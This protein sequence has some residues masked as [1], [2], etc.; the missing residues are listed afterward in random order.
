[1]QFAGAGSGVR[2]VLVNRLKEA[3]GKIFRLPQELFEGAQQSNRAE[4]DRRFRVDG[5]DPSE[6]AF[7]API[8][9]PDF[10]IKPKRVFRNE[11]LVRVRSGIFPGRV[12]CVVDD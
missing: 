11:A 7:S 3:S 8:L 12:I 2:G 10:E 1:L 5:I 4:L 6:D 9:Y